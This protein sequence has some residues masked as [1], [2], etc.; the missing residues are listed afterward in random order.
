MFGTLPLEARFVFLIRIPMVLQEFIKAAVK[1]LRSLPV[2]KGGSSVIVLAPMSQMSVLS[3][4]SLL[5]FN[6]ET[7]ARAA[8]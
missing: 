2:Q 8:S 1:R 5:R 4:S 6:K 7:C 3:G